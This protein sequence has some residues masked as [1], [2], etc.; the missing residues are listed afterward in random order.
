MEEPNLSQDI[1]D[2]YDDYAHSVIDRRQFLDKLQFFAVGGLT[3]TS[4]LKRIMPDYTG[5]I[6]ISEDD[7]RIES[8]MIS[9]D[10]PKGGGKIQAQLS[11]P[12]ESIGKLPVIIVAHEN[13]GLNPHIKDVARRASLAGYISIAPDG[14][15]SL[16]GY[17]GNDDD[18]R[19][20]HG[21]I[22]RNL[23]LEDFIAAYSFALSTSNNNGKVGVVGF[24]FGGWL[25]NMMAARIP[26][27]HA[28]VP[29]YGGQPPAEEVANIKAPLLLHYASMD[30]RVNAGWPAYEEALKKNNKEYIAHFYEGQQ[31]GFHNDTTARYNEEAAKLSWQ[32]TLEFFNQKLK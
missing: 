4:I 16:G 23:M 10:S 21:K 17:P 31:H 24:C 11:F 13:R 30:E 1:Y 20:M 9:Y 22:D 8:G 19:T 26:T 14:L 2:L 32:R 18:G 28:A 3:V 29:Y 12:K 6:Q 27:L 15:S 7:P 25:S 5:K